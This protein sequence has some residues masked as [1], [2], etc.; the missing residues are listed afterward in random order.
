MRI[1]LALI[2]GTT[3]ASVADATDCYRYVSYDGTLTKINTSCAEQLGVTPIFVR[4]TI[5]GYEI[6]VPPMSD[7]SSPYNLLPAAATEWLSS[8]NNLER[9]S[10]VVEF[11]ESN[12]ALYPLT[13]EGGIAKIE[14]VN[15][16]LASW[17]NASGAST[18]IATM[19]SNPDPEWTRPCQFIP[20]CTSCEYYYCI[21]EPDWCWCDAWGVNCCVIGKKLEPPLE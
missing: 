19:A 13:S 7:T 3:L 6:V 5:T 15:Y 18:A 11:A 20:A 4:D 17:L 1:F 12:A 16:T 9:V 2:F 14:Y 10:R 21:H 8:G